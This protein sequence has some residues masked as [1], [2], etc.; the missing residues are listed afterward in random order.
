MAPVGW[1]QVEQVLAA[2]SHT[3]THQLDQISCKVALCTGIYSVL[4]DMPS[5]P[6]RMQPPRTGKEKAGTSQTPQQMGTPVQCYN[7]NACQSTSTQF[8]MMKSKMEYKKKNLK[9]CNK[10][11]IIDK[12]S[13]H[14][15]V[16]A[17]RAQM[18]I[19]NKATRWQITNQCEK[20]SQEGTKH[21]EFLTADLKLAA[22][23]HRGQWC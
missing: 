17:E 14:V 21:E 19:N 2:N 7:N 11:R 8:Q 9:I 18:L 12:L 6:T 4:T 22:S 13:N 5:T 23:C 1:K 15:E 10:Q 3:T 20:L 16:Q